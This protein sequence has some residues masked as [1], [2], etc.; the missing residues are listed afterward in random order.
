MK[1]ENES[2]VVVA[3]TCY[4]T[5]RKVT[6]GNEDNLN[7]EKSRI[8]AITEVR[9]SKKSKT[10]T[11]D[12][13]SEYN[14]LGMRETFPN[15][16]SLKIGEKV[17]GIKMLNKTFPN[18]REVKSSSPHFLSGDMLIKNIKNFSGESFN[19]LLNAFCRKAE[20]PI[21]FEGVSEIAD[22]ALNGCLSSDIQCTSSLR[23]FFKDALK[24]SVFDFENEDT[25]NGD[26]PVMFGSCLIGFKRN[27]SSFN[28]TDGL[29][30]DNFVLLDNYKPITKIS[31]S[32]ARLLHIFSS[33]PDDR[34]ICDYLYISDTSNFR[35]ELVNQRIP[36]PA[37]HVQINPGNNYLKSENDIICNADMTTVEASAWFISGV[38][39]IPDGVLRVEE[40]GFLSD[41]IT[42]LQIPESVNYVQP[43]SM[44]NGD[45]IKLIE[46]KG[47]NL[48]R[49][50]VSAVCRDF[51][52]FND[53]R[54]DVIEIISKNAHVFIPRYASEKYISTIDMLCSED[55]ASAN[56]TFR[57]ALSNTIKYH[58]LKRSYDVLKDKSYFEIIKQSIAPILFF[59]IKDGEI[60]EA[61]NLV[62]SN[63]DFVKE[64]AYDILECIKKNGNKINV[65]NYDAFLT[66]FKELKFIS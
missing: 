24:G 63:Y 55:L 64:K 9:P 36:L 65:S 18:I 11:L 2:E 60:D 23:A 13:A 57:Y 6:I 56:D 16:T 40:N 29:G 19:I 22:L 61:V 38:V 50:C 53:D 30:I 32:R 41:S 10:L 58:V 27:T 20:E 26:G 49:G 34:M 5:D 35:S 42:E 14:L 66:K 8:N 51:L 15:I 33:I 12:K 25:W 48:P 31:V 47:E 54:D 37:A 17:T 7:I 62:T 45:K 39:K 28:L 46:T 21:N 52:P 59:L 4:S 44:W 43:G 1:K 3:Q